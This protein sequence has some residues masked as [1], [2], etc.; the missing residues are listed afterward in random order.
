M[1]L[2]TVDGRTIS[3]TPAAAGRSS[4]SLCC[5]ADPARVDAYRVGLDGLRL[6]R[7]PVWPFP[8]GDRSCGARRRPPAFD[9]LVPLDRR[10]VDRPGRDRQRSRFLGI[11]PIHPVIAGWRIIHA[12]HGILGSCRGHDSRTAW[13]LDGSLLDLD[14]SVNVRIARE[15]AAFTAQQ[16]QEL[17]DRT[18][19]KAEEFS[20][21]KRPASISFRR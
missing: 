14:R 10:R 4:R 3:R 8:A 5:R 7:S 15:F 21:F 19:R 18:K 16:M 20:Y 11:L 12:T 6:R 1:V 13:G 2:Y 9:G 17:E